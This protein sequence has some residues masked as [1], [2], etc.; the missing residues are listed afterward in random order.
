MLFVMPVICSVLQ[1]TAQ[2]YKKNLTYANKFGS[3][4][5]IFVK[6]VNFYTHF[7]NICTGICKK[8]S[9]FAP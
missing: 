7:F 3:E 9:N 8:S 4:V 1:K 2:R 6:S 5:K